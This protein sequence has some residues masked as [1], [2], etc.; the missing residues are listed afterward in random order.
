M[1]P[2]L[3]S[4]YLSALGVFV[5]FVQS[6][7]ATELNVGLGLQECHLGGSASVAVDIGGLESECAADELAE[8]TIVGRCHLFLAPCCEELIRIEGGAIFGARFTRDWRHREVC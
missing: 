4:T 2:S 8:V 3:A 1:L 7:L 6:T 5:P